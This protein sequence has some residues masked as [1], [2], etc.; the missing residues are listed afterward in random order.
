[1]SVLAHD[2]IDHLFI[3]LG[4]AAVVGIYGA[5]WLAQP[6]PVLWRLL[7]WIAGVCCVLVASLP[8]VEALAEVS[9]TGH[10]VQHLLVII[11]GAPLLVLGQPVHTS[12]R[13]GWLPTAH[14]SGQLADAG[15]RRGAGTRR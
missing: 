8:W 1:M 14:G 5:A 11:V 6:R 4:A 13:A 2:G 7:S 12:G 10:M 9:F 3:G 15:R